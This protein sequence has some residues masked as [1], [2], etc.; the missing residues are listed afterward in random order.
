MNPVASIHRRQ[1][2][3]ITSRWPKASRRS[4]RAG[5][6]WWWRSCVHTAHSW[7]EQWRLINEGLGVVEFDA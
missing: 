5:A 2:A 6:R 3:A 7:P 1:A 4:R